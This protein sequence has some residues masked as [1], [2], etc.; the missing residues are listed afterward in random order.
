[1]TTNHKGQNGLPGPRILYLDAYD[2]FTNNI[3]GLLETRIAANVTVIRVDDKLASQN[4]TK[5]ADS[6]DAI[7]VGPGPG[8]PANKNDVGLM[9]KVWDLESEH[10][11]PVLGICLGFQSLGYAFGASIGR[12]R[13][14]RHGIVSNVSH[15]D[16]DIFKGIGLLQATQYHSLFVD[17]GHPKTA[18]E[19]ELGRAT[20]KCHD[21]VPL[22]WDFEDR[23]NG[24]ILMAHRHAAKPFWGVQFH[25]ES[26]CTNPEGSRLLMNWWEAARTWLTTSRRGVKALLSNGLHANVPYLRQGPVLADKLSTI[27][28]KVPLALNPS[29]DDRLMLKWQRLPLPVCS[30]TELVEHL[31]FQEDEVV[32][33]DSQGHQS[34]RY[35]I[36]GVVSSEST[37]KLAY[38]L[39]TRTISWVRPGGIKVDQ[40]LEA[41]SEIWDVLRASLKHPTPSSGCKGLPLDS[42]FW[43]GWMG[44]ISYEAGLETIAVDIPA[45]S[46]ST[47]GCD[48]NLAFVKRSIVV[49][50]VKEA[51]Y[52]QSLDK[53]DD[54][55]GWLQE[56]ERLL[57]SVEVSVE[58]A[59]TKSNERLPSSGS[60][61]PIQSYVEEAALAMH[62]ENA[63]LEKVD[64]STYCSNVLKCQQLLSAGESYELCYTDETRVLIPTSME[65][66]SLYKRLRKNNAAPFGAF[67][68]L[69][70]ATV[71]GSS[72]ERFL[73]WDREGKCQFRPI[74]GTVRKTAD[75][76]R[77][78]AD[79]ILST[80]KE[81][82]ENL[83]IVDLIRH[84]LSGVI[85]A[86]NCSVTKLMQME[87]YQT[88][89]QLVSVI[90]GRLRKPSPRTAPLS[91][92][93][94]N[95]QIRT[96]ARSASYSRPDIQGLDVLKA[97][98]PPGSMTG[99]PK[100]R[101]CEILTQ[102]E[103][104]PRSIYSGV[105]GYMDVGGGGD[106]SVVIRTAFC[107][108]DEVV[109]RPLKQE[110]DAIE[111]TLVPHHVWRIGAGGAVTIQSTDKGEFD[112]MEA[113]LDSVLKTFQP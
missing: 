1:M 32:L 73:S 28:K 13:T 80:S 9:S 16:Q 42:P 4:F 29:G 86:Q 58:Q 107:H 37:T 99:A 98:L 101:S 23:D 61:G 74:K 90:E 51:L 97:S 45:T 103:K 57:S 68:R 59:R 41:E 67:L 2:S 56:V 96:S 91:E 33:L 25:L 18:H 48:I 108:D 14:A 30:L 15:H 34:G 69:S 47:H 89:Y 43:G 38:D 71:V 62:L 106:F 24:P 104:R 11:L 5:I 112:E 35:S 70:G 83:M 20:G 54:H 105:L 79:A 92:R 26:I 102:L 40:Q 46:A 17:L 21:L 3:I 72:P 94:A 52:I 63:V 64:E 82:A 77:E 85:G 31:G 8:H 109:D 10:V 44:Y 93:N 100:K 78:K 27:S 65:A 110:N 50:H 39:S 60:Q 111:T 49:D 84:D 12:L 76:T 6:F 22:A 88:V 75:M 113:K 53:S 36:I 66:W 55:D 81:R 19:T 7:V 95:S 87:E